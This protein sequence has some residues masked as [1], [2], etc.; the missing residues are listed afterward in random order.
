MNERLYICCQHKQIQHSWA[1]EARRLHF[2]T[3]PSKKRKLTQ[4]LVIREE[5]LK[6]QVHKNKLLSPWAGDLLLN[7]LR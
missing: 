7:V 5:H 2:A 4:E 3:V 1:G 6:Q